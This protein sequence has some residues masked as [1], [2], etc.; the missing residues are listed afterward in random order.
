MP[1]KKKVKPKVEEEIVSTAIE[2][3][4]LSAEEL[5]LTTPEAE[6][7]EPK[8]TLDEQLLDYYNN[9]PLGPLKMED[10]KKTLDATEEQLTQA[11]DRLYDQHLIE[12]SKFVKSCESYP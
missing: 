5:A 9:A 1:K 11:W 10:L 3:P 8:K 4:E 6:P 7:E 12:F 2:E